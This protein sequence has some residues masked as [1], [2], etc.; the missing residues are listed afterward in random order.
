MMAG[1]RKNLRKNMGEDYS[2]H[3]AYGAE[4]MYAQRKSESGQKLYKTKGLNLCGQK[5]YGTERS[6]R[7]NHGKIC[8]KHCEENISYRSECLQMVTECEKT[9]ETI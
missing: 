5:N 6:L 7:V 8:D 9:M 2:V 1:E 3:Y 4:K